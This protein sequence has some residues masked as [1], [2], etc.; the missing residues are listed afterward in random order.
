MMKNAVRNNLFR[1]FQVNDQVSSNLVQFPDDTHIVG[2]ASWENLRIIKA[3][4]K[5]FEL[6][7]GLSINMENSKVLGVGIRK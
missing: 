6:V 5:G 3:M 4:L 7:F 2:E 1:G